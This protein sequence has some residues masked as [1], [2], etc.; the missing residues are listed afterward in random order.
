MG[1]GGK[2]EVIV[3]SGLHLFYKVALRSSAAG[4]QRVGKHTRALT[5]CVE[6]EKRKTVIEP[7]VRDRAV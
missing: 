5:L 1:V 7:W 6:V 2:E 3:E 4:C